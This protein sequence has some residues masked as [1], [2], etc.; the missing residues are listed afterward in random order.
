M[1]KVVS[2]QKQDFSVSVRVLG[3][4][5]VMKDWSILL[6]TC[7]WVQKK[8]VGWIKEGCGGCARIVVD[9][10]QR[11]KMK[12]KETRGNMLRM[13]LCFC[14]WPRR[15]E[16]WVCGLWGKG[17]LLGYLR[18]GTFFCPSGKRKYKIGPAP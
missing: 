18:R 10:R 14:G 16:I 5:K 12:C 11:E 3:V 4:G 7:M 1:L 9:M 8:S 2:G 13:F 15:E 6:S 17:L